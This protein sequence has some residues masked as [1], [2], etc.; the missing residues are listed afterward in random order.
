M[1]DIEHA[2]GAEVT[3]YGTLVG[4]HGLGRSEDGAHTGNHAGTAEYE[5]YHGAGLHEGGERGEEGLVVNHQIND[6]GVV[7]AQNGIVKLHHLHAAQAE[8]FAQQALQN[9][10]GEV[11]AYAVR[12]EKNEGFFVSVHNVVKCV[13]LMYSLCL[14]LSSYF[15]GTRLFPTC[16]PKIFSERRKCR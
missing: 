8:T 13:G 15:C 14:R 3:T 1:A 2:V 4:L 11:L 5:G 10:A 9:D 16:V 12:L 6:V 7:L